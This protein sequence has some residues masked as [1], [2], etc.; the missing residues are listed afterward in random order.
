MID[1]LL[2]QRSFQTKYLPFWDSNYSAKVCR[3]SL[4]LIGYF[5][6]YKSDWLRDFDLKK[7]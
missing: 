6:I 2:L 7:K 4:S 5:I 3:V 1:N